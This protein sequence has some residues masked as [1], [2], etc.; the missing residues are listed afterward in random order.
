[1]IYIYIY[2]IIYNLPKNFIIKMRALLRKFI[3][4]F[5]HFMVSLIDPLKRL[6]VRNHCVVTKFCTKFTLLDMKP[7]ILLRSVRTEENIAAVSASVNDDHQLTI[8]RRS[9]QLGLCCSTTCK[10]MRKDLVVKPIKIQLVQEL[11]PNNLPQC[12]IFGEWALGKLAEIPLYF[13]REIV[14]SDE[15]QWVRKEA[16]L[17]ILE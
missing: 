2:Y 15:A 6:F 4:S 9:Q 11:K 10:I 17:S 1:M 16:E 5:C 8:R 14:F 12:R 13:Y 7:P 3:G